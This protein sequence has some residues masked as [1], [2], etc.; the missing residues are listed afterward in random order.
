[1][2]SRHTAY[3]TPRRKNRIIAG[4]LAF[5]V[6]IFGVH[7]FY[8]NKPAAGIFYIFLFIVTMGFF[9]VTLLLGFLEAVNFF[10]MSEEKF[11]RKY[12]KDVPGLFGDYTRKPGASFEKRSNGNSKPVTRFNP[13]TA[14]IPKKNPFKLSA[15]LKYKDFDLK[16]AIED[17]QKALML[18]EFDPDIHFD[19]AAIY[20]LMEQKEK[21]FHHLELA[22]HYGLKDVQKI[23]TYE[24]LAFVRIQD[25]FETF[26]DNGFRMT[27]K[28]EE[29][30]A[31]P[32][33]NQ[34]DDTLLAHLNKLAD[35]RKKG[36]ISEEEFAIE[37]EKLKEYRR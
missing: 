18:A 22:V 16:G 36:L 4:L 31:N 29:K 10:N 24:D 2:D 30:E 28:T 34:A 8:L 35:L 19:M 9:P 23:N 13:R 1:M 11:Q 14:R 26:R 5:V 25:E 21:A 17:Y 32:V 3:Q 15:G 12:N 27:A 20:S 6:G 37:K 7:H 33:E